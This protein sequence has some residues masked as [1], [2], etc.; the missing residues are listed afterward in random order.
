MVMLKPAVVG[1]S[2]GLSAASGSPGCSVCWKAWWSEGVLDNIRHVKW[3]FPTPGGRSSTGVGL[4]DLPVGE[5]RLGDEEA[6]LVE[7]RKVQWGAPCKSP[8][9]FWLILL[10]LVRSGGKHK[11]A[12]FPSWL[13]GRLMPKPDDPDCERSIPVAGYLGMMRIDLCEDDRH[14]RRW[15][16]PLPGGESTP[17]GWPCL[18]TGHP[19]GCLFSLRGGLQTGVHVHCWKVGGLEMTLPNFPIQDYTY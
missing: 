4:W 12:C 11:H 17:W 7:A 1:P 5:V 8:L 18:W 10:E 19:P 14:S 9:L 2:S 6:M 16:A 15:I 13:R 3:R